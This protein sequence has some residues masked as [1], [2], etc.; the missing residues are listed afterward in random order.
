MKQIVI[1]SILIGNLL[2]ANAQYTEM[3]NSNRPGTS[4]GAFAVGNKVLQ[5][6]SGLG[7]GWE[8]HRLLKTETDA[9]TIDYAIRYGLM[10]EQLEI[11]FMGS[12]LSE[13]VLDNK[14]P[15]PDEFSRSNFKTNTLG[16]K[17]LIYDPYKKRDVEKPN[18]YSYH[19]NNKFRWRELI[20]A[21]SVFA[22]VNLDTKDNP[23]LP[24]GD[25]N[26]TPKV[27]VSTQN[28]FEGGWV[29]VTNII[30]DRISSDFPTYSYIL[31]LTHAFNPKTSA[32]IENQGIKSDFYADQLFRFGGAYLLTNNFQVDALAAIN[33]K[34]TPSKFF[35]G[36]GASYRIDMHAKD[37]IIEE[38]TDKND[39]KEDKKKKKRKGDFVEEEI[40]Q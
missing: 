6:E 28:N 24:V 38:K 4:Q 36:I 27:I 19:A 37:E 39:S 32:F 8:D 15:V 5:F 34:D 11:N 14:S 18:L 40:E 9:F 17:Y 20:P 12:F 31:T 7:L 13:T 21:V 29:F 26:I 22:G 16:A 23:F 30:A 33:F 10:W 25:S 2:P 1:F 3:I 35:I